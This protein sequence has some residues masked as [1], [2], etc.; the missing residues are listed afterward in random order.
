MPTQPTQSSRREMQRMATELEIKAAARAQLSA[1]GIQHVTLRGIAR[2]MG[3]TAPALYRYFPSLDDL[4]ASMSKDFFDELTEA[5]TRAIEQAPA[6][7]GHRMHAAVRTFREWVSEHP[8]EFALMT[9]KDFPSAAETAG[10]TTERIAAM[11]FT[12]FVRLWHAQPFPVL[13]PASGAADA[14]LVSFA[15]RCLASPA[16]RDDPSAV[17]M[18]AGALVVFARTWVRLYGVISMDVSGQ[19][20]F[21]S[22][23]VTPYFES[24]LADAATALG[25][26]YVPQDAA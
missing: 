5:I 11:F 10:G 18:P 7:P 2:A 15:E 19:L 9:G 12:L 17:S 23:D 1:D 26:A 3:M 24:E 22:D 6:D 25:I 8:G 13:E 20:S 16:L 21:L 4:I 14:R